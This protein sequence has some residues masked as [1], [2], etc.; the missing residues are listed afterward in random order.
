MAHRAR[1]WL[2]GGVSGRRGTRSVRAQC[3]V[4]PRNCGG[5]NAGGA[6]QRR[7][8]HAFAEAWFPRSSNLPPLPQPEQITPALEHGAV[9]CV[10]VAL[11]H[12]VFI[13]SLN[14]AAFA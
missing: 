7:V 14:R 8:A 5:C 1:R 9:Q 3:P 13:S 11:V 6:A 2:V 12:L 4:A 10:V